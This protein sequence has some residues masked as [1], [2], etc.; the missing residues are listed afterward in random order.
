MN[1]SMPGFSVHYQLLEFAQTHVHWVGDAIQPSHPLFSSSPPAFNLSQ[2]QGLFQG[3][4]SW[5]QLAKV[6]E[7]RHQ[8]F[9]W[10]DA[11]R[12][13]ARTSKKFM[14]LWVL[15]CL[16]RNTDIYRQLEA[17]VNCLWLKGRIPFLILDFLLINF[18]A[19]VYTLKFYETIHCI[20]S[21]RDSFFFFVESYSWKKSD[22]YSSEGE[23]YLLFFMLS[24]LA[25]SGYKFRFAIL[26]HL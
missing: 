15:C 22:F 6:L 11:R 13:P 12:F 8:S 7:L 20:I 4:S 26:A 1:C 9:Q 23:K 2:H 10:T 24:L 17:Q 19:L 3:V 18:L 21:D 14:K 5:H 25:F 16:G